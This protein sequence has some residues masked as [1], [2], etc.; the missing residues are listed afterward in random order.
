MTEKKDLESIKTALEKFSLAYKEQDVT[1]IEEF[2]KEFYA[3]EGD[4]LIIG[5]A[6]KEW[7]E[8]YNGAKEL[9]LADWNDPGYWEFNFQEARI[10]LHGDNS[11]V[12]MTGKLI[13][14]LPP[15]AI[16]QGMLAEIENVVDNSEIDSDNKMWQI[17]NFANFY[18]KESKKGDNYIFPFRF[19]AI[20][21]KHENKW[22]FQQMHFS[23][24]TKL[25]N[26]FRIYE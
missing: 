10:N 2:M 13:M 14:Q 25:P 17:V 4:T 11:W 3:S 21:S 23:F 20:L 18:L 22:L 7:M 6:Y 1:K 15:E 24:P 9:F 19:T 12:S 5:T 16:F 26:V 8:G